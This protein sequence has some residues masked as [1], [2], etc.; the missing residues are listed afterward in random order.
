MSDEQT[1]ESG[2]IA[3]FEQNGRVLSGGSDVEQL[4]E[5]MERHAPAPAEKTPPG[6]ASEGTDASANAS[7]GSAP[8]PAAKPTRGQQRF[9]ELTAER[10]AAK[11]ERDA[12]KQ[13]RERLAAEFEA[14]KARLAQST[15]AAAPEPA[16]TPAPTRPEPTEDEIGTKYQGY[17]EF[18]RDLAKW[19]VEQERAQDAATFEQRVS[20]MWT[21]RQREQAFRDTAKAAQDRGRKVYADFDTLLKGPTGRIPMGRTETEA[22]TRAK[23]IIEHPQSEH[24]QYAIL[25]DQSLAERLQQS[26]D[27]TFGAIVTGLVPPEKPARPAWTPPPSPHPT[28]GAS[29]PTTPTP[30]SELAR[31]GFDFDSSG[32]REKRAAERAAARGGRR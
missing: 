6:P 13:E 31:K 28:V 2:G 25:K 32:Y 3:T 16:Q 24:I 21:Q 19:V 15:P 11:A 30:S 18:A 1:L 7:G 10:D 29:S 20:E 5:T 17:T 8:A 9:S 23:F 22:V 14:L 27:F 12:V 26:D 4:A